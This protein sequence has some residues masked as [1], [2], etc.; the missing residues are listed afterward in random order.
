[1]LGIC[2]EV[3]FDFVPD[4]SDVKDVSCLYK[5]Y[6]IFCELGGITFSLLSHIEVLFSCLKINELRSKLTL[7]SQYIYIQCPAHQ[8]RCHGLVADAEP[9]HSQLLLP[10]AELSGLSA[11]RQPKRSIT[12]RAR[13]PILTIQK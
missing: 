9:V 10:S 1:M 4:V 3:C 11:Q 6:K 2:F 7:G 5:K 13:P 12:V 8:F